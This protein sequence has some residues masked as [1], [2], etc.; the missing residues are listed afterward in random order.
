[1]DTLLWSPAFY[2]R[3]NVIGSREM[4]GTTPQEKMKAIQARYYVPNNTA[5][6]LSGAI[7][8]ARGFKL[9]A[10]VM[11]DWPRGADPFATPAPDPPPLAKSHAAIVELPVQAVA[12]M[13]R[14][15]GPSVSKDPGATYAAD[16]LSYILS[17]PSSTFQ[18]RLVDS[19][20]AFGVNLSY[21]TL[22]HVGPITAFAQTTPDKVVRLQQAILQEIERMTDSNYV[23]QEQLVAA[24]KQLGIQAL[25]EREQPTELAHTVGFWWSVA[26]LEYY[27]NYVPNMQQ[28]SRTDMARYAREY[29]HGKPMVTGVLI[30]PQAR[31]QTGLTPEKL[32]PGGMTP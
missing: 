14:W 3:K 20:L 8:P 1:V 10:D 29:V 32:I 22:N 18:R 27:R 19:G 26:S 5:L 31:Q 4:I 11:S 25:Y 15:Q 13:M 28:V 17:N 23:T 30:N 16:V 12:I 9:A 24:Q 7:T 6:I 2:S 21:Y